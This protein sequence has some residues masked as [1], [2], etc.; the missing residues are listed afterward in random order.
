VA[1]REDSD[2]NAEIVIVLVVDVIVV[3]VPT[4]IR[5]RGGREC[6]RIEIRIDRY[7][8]RIIAFSYRRF[9]AKLGT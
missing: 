8:L 9:I 2:T 3:D 1:Q 7:G 5:R 6:R 4:S